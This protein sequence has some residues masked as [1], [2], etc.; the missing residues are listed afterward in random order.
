MLSNC[1]LKYWHLLF[2]LIPT[3]VWSNCFTI[4]ARGGFFYPAELR[5]RKLYHHGGGEF[6]VEGSKYFYDN[7]SVWLN[8][9]YF[10]RHGHSLGFHNS[11]TVKIFPISIGLK[12][13][14]R[15]C[16]CTYLYLGAGASYTWVQTNDHSRFVRQD[17]TGYGWG[18]V[19]KSGIFF[20]LG[21]CWFLDL[22][23][24]YYYNKV[25]IHEHLSGL[26]RHSPNVGG[27]RSG[28]GI[29]VFF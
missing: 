6:E 22:F 15:I 4:Q 29:G 23:A 5:V 12:Y 18:G 13:A 3:A 11:T 28:F 10:P 2:F 19:G 25:S 14:F 24:D 21:S 20:N 26:L 27:L 8:L 7:F 9:N 1:K 16:H 17:L